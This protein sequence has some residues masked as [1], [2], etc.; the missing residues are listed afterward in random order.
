MFQE[1]T[2][3]KTKVSATRRAKESAKDDRPSS[4]TMGILGLVMVVSTFVGIFLLDAPTL[5]FAVKELIIDF[6]GSELEREKLTMKT[7]PE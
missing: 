6:K 5:A 3:D 1:L 7:V 4:Q 2:V